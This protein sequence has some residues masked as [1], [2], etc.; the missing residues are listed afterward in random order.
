MKILFI[1]TSSFFINIAI[2]N[3]N[4]VLTKVQKEIRT[5]MS[6]LILPIIRNSFNN[7]DFELKDL[8]KIFVV[9]GPGSFTGIRVG[10][11]IAKTIAWGFNIPIVPVSSLELLAT[12]NQEFEYCIPMI[13]ARRGNVFGAVYDKNLNIVLKEQLISKE[14]LLN[15][16]N[17]NYLIISNDFDE[18]TRPDVDFIKIIKKHAEDKPSNPHHLNPKYLKLTE[19]EEKLKNA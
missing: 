18:Y 3:N 17:S 13:D 5:D 12:T 7:V 16:T 11:S 8:E 1:D 19:A 4:K 9:N 10:V 2:I 15:K 6:S 14:E